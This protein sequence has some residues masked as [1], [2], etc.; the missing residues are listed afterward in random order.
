MSI[1]IIKKLFDEKLRLLEKSN[2]DFIVD[3]FIDLIFITNNSHDPSLKDSIRHS[4]TKDSKYSKTILYSC[5]GGFILYRTYNYNFKNEFYIEIIN[6]DIE[7]FVKKIPVI[8]KEGIKLN[9]YKTLKNTAG[10]ELKLNRTFKLG[11][12][13]NGIKI[14]FF[15]IDAFEIIVSDNDKINPIVNDL[16]ELLAYEDEKEK[17]VKENIHL[18]SELLKLDETQKVII[19]TEGKTDWKYFLTALNYFHSIGEYLEIKNQYFLRFGSEKDVVNNVCG[20]KIELSNSVTQLNKFLE[21]FI[22]SEKIHR[23]QKPI[24]KIGIFDSDDKKAK[25][26]NNKKT[27]TFSLKIEPENI[28]T[29][30]LFSDITIKTVINGKRL[31]IGEE[32]D[33]RTKRHLENTSLNLGGDN[34]N[35]NKASKRVIIDSNVFD[36][37]GNDL[38]LSKEHF[39]NYIFKNEIDVSENEWNNFRH[40]FDRLTLLI[41]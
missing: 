11:G 38:T 14:G 23:K 21:S 20:T 1:N 26:I 18:K 27:N 6:E 37:N 19:I 13:E 3:H 28:S 29:E 30:L 16:R 8:T 4:V 24:I 39:A 9:F 22:T 15:T 35:L 41:K 36:E 32:F 7:D 33:H 34:N 25:I 40:V 2:L 10:F 12:L 5:Y 31:F 17:I